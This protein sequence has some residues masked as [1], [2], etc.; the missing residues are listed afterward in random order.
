METKVHGRL[1]AGSMITNQWLS[2]GP[3]GIARL[4]RWSALVEI[5]S[6]PG[7]P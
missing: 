5:A 7:G 1:R 4:G 3:L 6:E 2:L